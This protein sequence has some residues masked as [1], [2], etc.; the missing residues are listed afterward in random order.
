VTPD[1]CDALAE[2]GGQPARIRV[3]TNAQWRPAIAECRLQPVLEGGPGHQEVREVLVWAGPG[4]WG[5]Y[6]IEIRSCSDCMHRGHIEVSSPS[7][8]TAARR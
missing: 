8:R 2:F 7:R 1:G 6:G 4:A 5:A 3:Q